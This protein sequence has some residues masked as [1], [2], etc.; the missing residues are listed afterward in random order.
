MIDKSVGPR[1]VWLIVMT[2]ILGIEGYVAVL[3][4]KGPSEEIKQDS[5]PVVCQITVREPQEEDENYVTALLR[6]ITKQLGEKFADTI[7]AMLARRSAN[8]HWVHRIAKEDGEINIFVLIINETL[9]KEIQLGPKSGAIYHL[10]TTDV[11]KIVDA[12][13]PDKMVGVTD[14]DAIAMLSDEKEAVLIALANALALVCS[15]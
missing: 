5:R 3:R 8:L 11:N 1:T 14:R 6:G 12:S 2:E 15:Q 4:K 10:H 9:L 13:S 7:K